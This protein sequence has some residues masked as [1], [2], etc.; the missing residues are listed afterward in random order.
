MKEVVFDT[1]SEAEAQQALDYALYIENVRDRCGCN[2][3]EWVGPHCG[4]CEQTTAWSTPRERLD[5]RWAYQICKDQDYTG[6]TVEDYKG[7]N[8]PNPEEEI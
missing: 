4:Y 3:P 7:E 5:G 8:Y 2:D 6:M 1:E